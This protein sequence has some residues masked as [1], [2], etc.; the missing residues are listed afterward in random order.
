MK[1]VNVADF[2]THLWFRFQ[3]VSSPISIWAAFSYHIEDFFLAIAYMVAY[4]LL[5]IIPCVS[6]ALI[7]AA[8]LNWNENE[9]K[10]PYKFYLAGLANVA[11]YVSI[12]LLNWYKWGEMSWRGIFLLWGVIFILV[13][14]SQLSIH[15]TMKR[16]FVVVEEKIDKNVVSLIEKIGEKKEEE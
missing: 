9:D 2:S 14:I 7:L 3:L 1:N 16:H 15:W 4:G 5:S 8:I 10:P 11:I 6:Y 12:P 13:F